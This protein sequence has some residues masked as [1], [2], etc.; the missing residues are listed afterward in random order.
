MN[1]E[2]TKTFEFKELRERMVKTPEGNVYTTGVEDVERVNKLVNKIKK[3]EMEKKI[4]KEVVQEGLKL[5]D[6]SF[7]RAAHN[8]LYILPNDIKKCKK[9]FELNFALND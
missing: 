8:S 7:S 9:F 3:L 5:L 6:K 4:V 2:I 1:K